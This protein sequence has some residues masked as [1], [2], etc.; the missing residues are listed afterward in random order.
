MVLPAVTNGLPLSLLDPFDLKCIVVLP[1]RSF[2]LAKQRLGTTL[3]DG[4]RRS[5][6]HSL[7]ET[8]AHACGRL[9][10]VVVS[11]DPDVV[12]W[13]TAHLFFTLPDPGSLNG[14]ATTGRAWAASNG[15]ARVV[16]AHSDLPFADDLERV[17]QPPVDAVLVPD[18]HD[19]GNPVFVLPSY[20]D[21]D[22]AYGPRSF[23]H[24]VERAHAAGW[25]T[26]VFRDHAL[27]FDVDEPDDL[28]IL[29][30]LPPKA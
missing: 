2:A 20:G 19:D 23:H 4:E 11:S 8:V 18:R 13:A 21:F 30:Q 28:A 26:F 3:D 10:T 22:F 17:L 9:T 25:Q 5:L 1:I 16:I 29:Q 6:A 27:G 24:H 12:E 14:A 7:A 15:I